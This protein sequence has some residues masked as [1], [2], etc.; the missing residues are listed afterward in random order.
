MATYMLTI[1]EEYAS[2]HAMTFNPDKSKCIAFKPRSMASLD[3]PPFYIAGKLIDYTSSWPHLGNIISET[4][5]DY[6]C[7]AARRIQLIGQ[8]NNVLSTFGKLNP[9]TKN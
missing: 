9:N 5:D 4:E 2:E 3:R 8:V 1:C 7:I 6:D